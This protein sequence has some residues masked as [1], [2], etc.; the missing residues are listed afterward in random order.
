MKSRLL[1]RSDYVDMMGAGS[2]DRMLAMLADTG[3]S[4]DVEQALVR[5]QGLDR[6]DRTLRT[7]LARSLTKMASFY[8]GR[9]REKIDVLVGRWDLRNLRALVR[10]TG[11]PMTSVDPG[12][13]LV[14]AGR[15]GEAELTELAAQGDVTTLVDLLVAWG[16]PSP[17]SAFALLRARGEYTAEGDIWVL[18]RAIDAVFAT[19]LDR[20]L[21]GEDEGA[22]VILRAEIDARNL[23][24]A[25]RVRASR[26]DGEPGWSDEDGAARYLLG[27]IIDR[28][29]WAEIAEM[30]SAE[31][32]AELA[33]R[34]S[35]VP[36]WDDAVS[37]W[38]ADEDLIGLS[39]RLQR[40]IT[41][42]AVSR[43]VRGD[44]LGFDI[45][46]AFT[47]AKEAEVRNLRLI[48]RA[49]VH[50]LPLT[51]VEERLEMAA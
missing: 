24:L 1:A 15:L 11:A 8:E 35:P 27:G 40:G 39:D 36:G 32:I 9:P 30:E 13:V 45:P 7:N 48:G 33:T 38:A 26:R 31:A 17:D 37:S 12:A 23:E 51:E 47:F 20:V 28:E 25:L 18:E 29:L 43:F 19:E 21:A 3:Y 22:V 46:V 42:T 2:L 5:G 50:R 14:P 44:P 16:I 41:S 10:L 4:S 34:R 49:L 6:L